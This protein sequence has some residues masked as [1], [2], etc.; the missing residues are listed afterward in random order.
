VCFGMRGV[1]LRTLSDVETVQD[2]GGVFNMGGKKNGGVE[3]KKGYIYWSVCD[4]LVKF[5]LLVNE[6]K[7]AQPSA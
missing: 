6:H 2:A 3:G 1:V 7:T 4:I 5:V